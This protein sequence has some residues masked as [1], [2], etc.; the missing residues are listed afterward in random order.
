MTDLQA[1]I[2]ELEA[3]VAFQ[4]DSLQALNDVVA[5]Q[6]QEVSRLHRELAALAGRLKG[7]VEQMGEAD[8]GGYIASSADER[9]PHY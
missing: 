6:D 7:L 1:R 9:P 2:E 4:D 3:R 5:R 8:S